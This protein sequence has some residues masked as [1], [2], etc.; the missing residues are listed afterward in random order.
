MSETAIRS[1]RGA[2][3]SAVLEIWNRALVRDPVSQE[4]FVQSVFC[5]GDYVPGDDSGFLV[6]TQHDRP[7]G[8]LR[9]IIRRWPND[10]VGV[11]PEDGWIPV[12]AVDPDHQRRGVGTQLLGAAL[13]Y[14]KVHDRRRIWVCGKTGSAPGYVFCGV[15]KDAYPGGLR[16]FHQAGFVT[17]NEPVAM[18]REITTFDVDGWAKKFADAAADVQ[19]AP[20]RSEQVPDFFAF[21]AGEFPGDWNIAAR[22]KIKSGELDEILVAAKGDRLVGYCQWEGEHFGPFGVSETVRNQNVGAR[23]FIESIRRIRAADGRHA[24]FNWADE[25]VARFYR[26][27][28]F[29]ATRQFAILAKDL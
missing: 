6:A 24:W 13:D 15:D 2:D 5:D 20:L 1:L 26:R 12:V 16:L 4:R 19:I 17:K 11:E 7:I 22:A 23:L 25:Q 27:F 9:A 21:L 29:H 3:L 28:G 10:R 8:F 18:S 14:F